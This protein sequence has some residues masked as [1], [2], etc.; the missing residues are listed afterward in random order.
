MSAAGLSDV[1]RYGARFVGYLVAVTLRGG[2]FVASGIA[3]GFNAVLGAGSLTN[4]AQ[5]LSQVSAASVAGSL[6][7]V[8]VGVLVALAGVVGLL[9]KLIADAAMVG[10]ETAMVNA[11]PDA[12]ADEAETTEA[13]SDADDS[14]ETSEA[15]EPASDEAVEPAAPP[16]AAGDSEDP[17]PATTADPIAGD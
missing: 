3:F 15:T 1:Y 17:D 11:G 5:L 16:N 14:A 4:P 9:Y 7:L 6:L 10:T 8:A 12:L 13:V 2:V